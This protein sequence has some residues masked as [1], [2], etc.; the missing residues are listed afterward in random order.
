MS[1][2]EIVKSISEILPTNEELAAESSL[3][4]DN[5]FARYIKEV[6]RF[7]ML[8]KEEE[9]SLAQDYYKNG[10]IES[11]NALVK[12][13]LRLVVKTALSY[14]NYN[15]SL[16]DLVAEGN[17]GLLRAVKKFHPDMGYRFSTYAIWW[18]KAY[19]QDFILK[20]WSLVK[21][22]TTKLHRKIF[23]NLQAIKARLQ[24]STAHRL[25][26]AQHLTDEYSSEEAK[27]ISRRISGRDVSLS[28]SI[29]ETDRT[30]EDTIA[31]NSDTPEAKL[32]KNDEKALRNLSFR[33][34][35]KHLSP[36]ERDIIFKRSLADE[37]VT[38]DVLSKEY[39]ISKERVRQIE[40]R[41]LARLEFLARKYYNE[42]ST[43]KV[44]SLL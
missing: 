20:S 30:L 5:L 34:A 44:S 33:Y 2:N 35:I 21:I 1:N 13:H 10:T 11:A 18:I 26:S 22:G 28:A 24:T 25:K 19:M 37:K 29:N 8:S 7:P 9:F 14:K 31:I 40:S 3:S 39:D 27:D 23:F 32:V 36:R 42:V 6:N 15:L 12:S 17:I 43:N 38:L 41:A 16:M 4:K